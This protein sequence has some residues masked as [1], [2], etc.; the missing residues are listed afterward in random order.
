M[1]RHYHLVREA[2]TRIAVAAELAVEALASR[3]VEQEPEFTDRMLGSIEQA[4]RQYRTKGVSWEAKTLTSRGRGSQEKPYGAD[5]LGVLSINLPQFT[6]NKG[7]LAQAK[8]IGEKDNMPRKEYKRLCKQC[9]GMLNLSPDSFVFLYSTKS[10]RIVPAISI[11][12]ANA[13][14]PHALYTRSFERFFEAH[15]ES[16]IG[17]RQIHTPHP[18]TLRELADKYNARSALSLTAKDGRDNQDML[19]Y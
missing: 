6:V 8:I 17:D 15:F 2:A 4:M 9:E 19:S 7:F 14:N 1:L 18:D 11:V 5:F 13:I 3:R 10:I 16:F 12:S